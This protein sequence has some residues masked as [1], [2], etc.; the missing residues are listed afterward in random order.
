[1]LSQI[2]RSM[3]WPFTLVYL[4]L[5]VSALYFTFASAPKALNSNGWPYVQ[6]KI[7]QSELIERKRSN[8][9]SDIISVY[10][11]KIEYQ[12]E[13]DDNNYTGAEIKW[14]DGN[15]D[16]ILA[17]I[18]KEHPAGSSVTVYYNPQKPNEAILQKGLSLGYILIGSFLLISIC[19]MAFALYSN[20]KKRRLKLQTIST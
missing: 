1:M 18:K 8:K 9:N 12:Y 11:A 5:I 3:G 20:A 17:L 15:S 14:A 2:S 19:A 6:G 13:I 10:S 16:K 7:T 4:A